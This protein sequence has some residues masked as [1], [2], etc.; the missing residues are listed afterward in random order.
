MTKYVAL[1]GHSAVQGSG[2]TLGQP[3]GFARLRYWVSGSI[4]YWLES[5]LGYR[6]TAIAKGISAQFP[7]HISQ[8]QG[9]TPITLTVSGNSV[10]AT[11][12]V[13][14]T[15]INNDGPFRY[16]GAFA[17]EQL[18]TVLGVPMKLTTPGDAVDPPNYLL[19]QF[20]GT[21]A[22]AVPVGS[23]FIIADDIL[24][25]AVNVFWH[26]RNGPFSVSDATFYTDLM[27]QK[28]RA[29]SN[30]F[31]V[32]G[33]WNFSTGSE[34]TG[35]A[36]LTLVNQINAALATIYGTSFFDVRAFLRGDAPY[37]GSTYSSAFTLLGLTPS[38]ADA[39]ALALGR[40]PDTFLHPANDTN[41]PNN[42]GYQA[43]ALG[44][45]EH[46]MVRKGWVQSL[47]GGVYL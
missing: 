10:P 36:N 35:S 41:H 22:V 7:V 29:K 25:Y 30:R 12:T 18:G 44:L 40:I 16:R 23:T 31:I 46:F 47:G 32:M 6:W 15:A 42:V 38:A 26:I 33:T 14:V 9:S 20:A 21:A 39:T 43:A 34:D 11:G 37:D 8:R 28:V 2:A 27:A 24:D 4:G 19:E 45:I 13:A 1:W 3:E 5:Y 17:N